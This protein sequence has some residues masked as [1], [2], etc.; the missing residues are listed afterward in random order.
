MTINDSEANDAKHLTPK[1][2]DS[3]ANDAKCQRREQMTND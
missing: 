1:A 2:T 3:D